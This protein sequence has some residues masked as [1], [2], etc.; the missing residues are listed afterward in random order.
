MCIQAGER[1]MNGRNTQHNCLSDRRRIDPDSLHPLL[2]MQLD[3]LIVALSQA[4]KL[5][6]QLHSV[7]TFCISFQLCILISLWLTRHKFQIL[8]VSISTCS[9]GSILW[10]RGSVGQREG[11]QLNTVQS[12][13]SLV[14]TSLPLGLE[15]KLQVG[16]ASSSLSKARCKSRCHAT[17]MRASGSELVSYHKN[18]QE[19]T[20]IWNLS[21]PRSCNPG[22]NRKNEETQKGVGRLFCVYGR[23]FASVWVRTWT[24]VIIYFVLG[25]E[26]CVLLSLQADS[27]GV[28]MMKICFAEVM[29]VAISVDMYAEYSKQTRVLRQA[30]TVLVY[31]CFYF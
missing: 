16:P 25:D 8:L 4:L 28:F 15:Q 19:W 9:T 2:D 10:C 30:V 29:Q 1:M 11:S 31:E 13:P 20:N 23:G 3:F 18:I 14:L 6:F 22:S 26:S 5:K 21:T 27:S 12:V 17:A 7:N 24:L